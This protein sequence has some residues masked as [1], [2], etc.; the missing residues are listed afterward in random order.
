MVEKIKTTDEIVNEV[1]QKLRKEV[2]AILWTPSQT[3]AL[4]WL[5]ERNGDGAVIRGNVVLA[6][7]EVGPFQWSTWRALIA[8]GAC[9]GYKLGKGRRIKIK[10]AAPCAPTAPPAPK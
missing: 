4:K 8:C 5:R 6:A 10:D 1:G 2:A 7:G 3:E 9:E